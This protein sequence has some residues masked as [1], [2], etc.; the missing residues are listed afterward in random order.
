M[1]ERWKKGMIK[2]YNILIREKEVFMLIEVCK[3]WMYV[4]G[5]IVYNYIYIGNVCSVIVFDMI[6][7]YFEYCGYEVN[8]VLN[9]IDVDDKIIKVVKELKI[10]VLE[11]VECF[12]KVFEEDM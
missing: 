10:I 5:L 3:V 7:C 6:C 1:E 4:C 2:I 9:F 12:I 8:Y 11:V